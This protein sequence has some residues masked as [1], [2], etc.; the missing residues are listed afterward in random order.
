MILPPGASVEPFRQR[1]PWLGPDLQTIRDTVRR[2]RLPPVGGDAILLDV[3]EGDRLLGWLDPP[4]RPDPLALV[5][6]LP[7]LG[8]AADG[9]GPR[10][11]SLA[12]RQAGLA[13]LRLNLRGAG[14]GRPLARGTYAAQ[15]NSD[16]LPVLERARTLA[17]GRPL[18]AV[19]LS[20]GG[21]MLLN[22]VLAEGRLDGLVCLSSPLDLE[23]A[24]VQIEQR[25]NRPYQRWLV[26]R[27]CRQTLA[28]PFG[29][30]ETE[31]RALTGSRRA[32]TIRHFDAL[33]TAPRWQYRSVA[34]YYAE[35]S[36]L[37]KLLR[38]SPPLPPT[39]I[40]H[41]Q[42][43]P[44]VPVA[45][46]TAVA[47]ARLPGV[48]VLLPHRGG[49]NGFHGVGDG[50]AGCWSDRVTVQWLRQLVAPDVPSPLP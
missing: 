49:H 25:R 46:A 32:T 6:V 5:L 39:L 19:G 11:L 8:G 22:L 24:M 2:P 18:L 15:C 31:R 48:E 27:L 14:A 47:Q 20:L 36:P 38:R 4:E 34:H 23:A 30:S 9:V 50:P 45:A 10:R 35:A 16:L 13:V 40:V 12:L 41:A 43:D 26:R 17:Q 44:W 21:T 1:F 7:G 3:G 29:V 28:D 33:I 42:D 37:P